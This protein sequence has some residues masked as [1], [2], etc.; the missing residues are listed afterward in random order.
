LGEARSIKGTANAKTTAD[1]GTAQ[2]GNLTG[3]NFLA[4]EL[5]AKRLELLRE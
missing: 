5:A 4:G 2:D 1:I 3:V